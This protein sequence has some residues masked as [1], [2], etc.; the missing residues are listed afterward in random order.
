M[1][2]LRIALV[3]LLALI[4]IPVVAAGVLIATY[5]VNRLKPRIEA[6]AERLTGRHV[7]FA[8]DLSVKPSLVPTLSAE[9]VSI[10]NIEGGSRP[11]MA[12]LRRVELQIA[13]LPLLSRRVEVSRIVL[14]EPDIVLERLADGRENWQLG[15]PAAAP[16][17][18]QPAPAQPAPSAPASSQDGGTPLEI[19]ADAI[20]IEN[21]RL[22]FRDARAGTETRFDLPRF[23]AALP[24]N[25][26]MT[27]EAEAAMNGTTAKLS[28]RFGPLAQLMARRTD[29]APWPVSVT[30]EAAGARATAEGSIADLAAFG[31]WAFAVDAAV[32]DMAALAPFAPDVPLPA[33]RDVAVKAQV[34]DSGG[35]IPA[36]SALT[37]TAGAADLQ[38]LVEGLH[39]GKL[40][41]S[42]PAADQ[43]M[44]VAMEATFQGAPVALT[45]TLGAPAALLPGGPA[46]AFPVDLAWQAA[47]ASGTAK[48]SI[49]DPRVPSG[50]NVLVA[51][52]VPDLAAV[53]KLAGASL[54]PF[55]DIAAQ[56]RLAERGTGFAGGAFLRELSLTMPQADATGEI[57]WIVGRRQEVQV[58]LASKRIDADAILAMLR[59]TPAAPG[60]A[61]PAGGAPPPPP[62]PQAQASTTLIPDTPLPFEAL[63]LADAAANVTVGA[64]T[65]GGQAWSDVQLAATL[66][67]GQLAVAPLALTGPG[68]RAELRVSADA[69]QPAPPVAVA[70]KA[71]SLALGPLMQALGQGQ[72]VTGTMQ[73]DLDI[74]GA[75]RTPHAI[76]STA[77]GHFG[78][79]MAGGDIDNRIVDALAGDIL[80]AVGA[81]VSR[82]GRSN[83]RCV[84]LRLDA[85]KGVAQARAL[86]ADTAL[87]KLDGG[88]AIN[89]GSETM[90]LRVRPTV[91]AGQVRIAAPVL[92]SGPWLGPKVGLDPAGAGQIA[93]Q[94]LGGLRSGQNPL[95]AL[96]GA[97]EAT[98]AD[99]C[100]RQLA[101]ARGGAA[102]PVP[103]AEAPAA[104]PQQQQQQPQRPQPRDLLR[105]LL[106]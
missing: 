103:A 46:R 24:A 78:A 13:L 5:D 62:L 65:F 31:G 41:V 54:P 66:K 71:P 63:T 7:T 6:E 104:S 19:A 60:A 17:T 8:G 68:G 59:A 28:G 99:D 32:P 70:V 45:G 16:S 35:P 102:G 96:M 77:T 22:L 80:R 83:I 9:Q 2:L 58:K 21:G 101:I 51:A 53:G 76:A 56:A 81:R 10:A 15:A 95:Q 49:A 4:V 85:D 30:L 40:E 86:L 73:L 48:G 91:K 37:V 44:R 57:T 50:V 89:M 29:G 12:T 92:V 34:K 106:R 11:E 79:A 26:P 42:A 14:V 84:A 20:R 75:G 88:G 38:S 87:A 64:L 47:G 90:A 43:P 82:E 18:A 52:T 72:A 105:N 69:R 1:K 23:D 55:R 97:G 36:F 94:V 25:A 100:P 98:S 67:E 3:T 74:K 27:V 61:A 39:L 33:L 93:G